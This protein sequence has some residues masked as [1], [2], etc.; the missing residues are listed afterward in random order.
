MHAD[1]GDGHLAVCVD[2]AEAGYIEKGAKKHGHIQYH[3]IYTERIQS[4]V[5]NH[6]TFLETNFRFDLQNKVLKQ[7]K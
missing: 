1:T 5:K 4:F 2:C 6:Q 7:N 3:P